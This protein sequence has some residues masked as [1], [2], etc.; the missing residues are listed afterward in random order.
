MEFSWQEYWSGLLF[1]TSEDLPDPGIEP[2]SCIAGRLF[3]SFEFTQEFKILWVHMT[4]DYLTYI[5]FCTCWLELQ[6]LNP[7]W[8]KLIGLTW[9]ETYRSFFPHNKSERLKKK[10]WGWKR[11]SYYKSPTWNIPHSKVD[12]MV[13]Q[14]C[15]QTRRNCRRF[16][17][18]TR[19]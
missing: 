4:W 7:G 9:K 2:I 16:S 8:Q 5:N 19:K 3:T 18:L 10:K 13:I 11:N 14:V 12:W 1:S 6:M 15:K 17:G